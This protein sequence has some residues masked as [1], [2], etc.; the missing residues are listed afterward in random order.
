MQDLAKRTMFYHDLGNDAKI[1]HVLDKGSMVANSFFG[2]TYFLIL[3]ILIA[4]VSI[5]FSNFSNFN[6]LPQLMRF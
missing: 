4:P 3:F 1:N 5:P 6:T 2:N